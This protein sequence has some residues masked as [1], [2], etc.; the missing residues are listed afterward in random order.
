MPDVSTVDQ[1]V[2]GQAAIFF[3]GVLKSLVVASH[4]TPKKLAGRFCRSQRRRA[5]YR[6]LHVIGHV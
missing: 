1:I 2:F 5:L 4:R 3:C 6:V